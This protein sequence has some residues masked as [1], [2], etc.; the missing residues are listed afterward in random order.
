[1][2]N[3]RAAI[4]LA[5]S[6][7]YTTL[8]FS[9][10]GALCYTGGDDCI[11]RLWKTDQGED[12]EPPTA[13]EAGESIT[14]LAASNNAWFSGSK[15]SDVRQYKA[16]D[17]YMEAIPL[18]S[19]LPSR[20]IINIEDIVDVSILQGHNDVVRKVTWEPSG[21]F[22]TSCSAD[23]KIIV[24]D[25]TQQ[26]PKQVKLIDGI[27]P[28]V[29]DKDSREFAHDCSAVWHPSGQYF[30]VASRT[31]DIIT[32]ARDSWTKTSTF[33]SSTSTG[34]IYALALSPNGVYLASST[35]KDVHVWS[36]QTRRLLFTFPSAT[37]EFITQLSFSPT[38]NILAWTDFAG[39]LYRWSDPIP[40]S[41]PSPVASTSTSAVT[42]PVRRGPTPT[43]FDDEAVGHTSKQQANE[44]VGVGGADDF[45]NEDWILDD[46]GDG[47]QDDVGAHGDDGHDFVKEMVSVTKAQPAFQ[48]G[49]TPMENRKR[50]LVY[51]LI[52]VIEVTDQDTHHIIN[53]EFHDRSS[54]KAYH[55]TDHFKYDLASLG[56]RGAV[57][58]C[59]PES[60]HSAHVIY[61]P[62]GNWA[63]QGEWTYDL[64]DNVRVLGVAAGGPTPSKSMRTLSDADLQGNGNVVV[65][66]SDNELTFL[67]G[68]GIERCSIALDGDFVSMVAGT[69]WV[70]VVQRDG[71]T[72][73]DGSQNLM[74]TLYDFE[75]MCV[76]QNR[77][78]PIR[79][80]HTLRWIGLSEEGAPAVYDSAGVMYLMPR[81][82]IPLRGT[83]LRI[84][85]TNKLERKQGKDESYW[86]VGLVRTLHVSH[87]KGRQ[88]HPTF[89]RPLIQEL[90]VRLPFRG[91]DPKDAP[92]EEHFARESMHLQITRDALSNEDVPDEIFARELALDKELVQLIQTAC[93]NDKLPRALELTN[94]LHHTSSFDMAVK[95]AGFYRLLG[96]QEKMEALK[97]DRITHGRPQRRDWARDYDPNFGSPAAVHRPGL[98]RA[99][100]SLPPIPNDLAITAVTGE[101]KRKWMDDGDD[102]V[103]HVDA[104]QVESARWRAVDDEF[105]AGAGASL[106]SKPRANPFAKKPNG[107]TADSSRN[108][109]GRDNPNNKSLHKSE[110]FFDKAEA[111]ET[112]K[113]KAGASNGRGQ[114]RD[115][116]KQTTLF[117]LPAVPAPDRPEKRSRKKGGAVASGED[118]QVDEPETMGSQDVE[119]VELQDVAATQTSQGAT[120]T[121][122]DSQQESQATEV[123]ATQEDG[124]PEPIEWPPTPPPMENN[125]PLPDEICTN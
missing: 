90:P 118:S 78:L 123:I 56:P 30:V 22:L 37:T 42:R 25:L 101:G 69:E 39:S 106:P 29:R 41:S 34:S 23:G 95:V 1:M 81:F 82:R 66:T 97:E 79:K 50:Y 83:W 9:R 107:T 58:A 35:N 75:D 122:V 51:N 92:L 62:Y 10:D 117:G 98:A 20:L 104:A 89:P 48:P 46:V 80:G 105:A 44:D 88:E 7:G 16:G 60:G 85:D 55:F 65:A 8:A 5:H 61:K 15:D 124:S 86:P 47:M 31:H 54:R 93:K 59:Q 63:T 53:V 87:P 33:S 109:F 17:P 21:S 57:Y 28:A 113:W 24:W 45:E 112:G 114:K 70:F 6:P 119:M 102:V 120:A 94:M 64:G 11:V 43:L 3:T 111:A 4:N 73:M 38:R 115:N 13:I 91:K 32:I 125:L 68:T 84:L 14:T 110:S 67:T 40:S 100:P 96:L 18:G 103:T 52:G 99:T 72:T 74:G 2:S 71:S 76:L 36:T 116:T 12:Q 108:P 27:I 49:S 19:G 26:E 121:V 77:K